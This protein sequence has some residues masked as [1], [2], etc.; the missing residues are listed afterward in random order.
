MYSE[1]PKGGELT[2]LSSGEVESI[3]A[4]ASQDGAYKHVSTDSK[5]QDEDKT[6]LTLLP[7]VKPVSLH[8]PQATDPTLQL[9]S[10]RRGSSGSSLPRAGFRV[11]ALTEQ[12][13]IVCLLRTGLTRRTTTEQFGI[14]LAQGGISRLFALTK[15]LRIDLAR[16]GISRLCLDGAVYRP[17]PGQWT[18]WFV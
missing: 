2:L 13:W 17:C 9:T 8:P 15:Q 18:V 5:H 11:Y 10:W 7:R 3:E 6:R 4:V 1:D 12:F 14:D 16:G